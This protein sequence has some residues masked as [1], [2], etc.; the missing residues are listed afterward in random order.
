MK[1][2]LIKDEKKLYRKL[3]L[4][5]SILYKNVEFSYDNKISDQAKEICKALNIKDKVKRIEYVYDSC[6]RVI[7]DYYKDKNYCDFVDGQ[8]FCQR[9]DNSS[10]KNGCCQICKYQSENGCPTQNLS[11]KLFYCDEVSKNNQMLSLKELKIL[12]VFNLRRR[13]IAIDNFFARKEDVIKDIEMGSLLL[14]SVRAIIRIM[15]TQKNNKG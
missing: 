7:E 15:E 1:K 8:C 6:I 14:Y 10:R 13:I 3:F 9:D 5:R 11:C 2:V 4:Y 12:K